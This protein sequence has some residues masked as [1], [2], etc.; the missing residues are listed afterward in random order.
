MQ[1]DDLIQQVHGQLS[2][3]AAL[4]DERTREIAA[5]LATTLDPA[6]RLAIISALADAADEITVA[7][8]DT[9]GSPAISLRLDGDQ[10]RVEVSQSAPKQAARAADE[11]ELSARISFRLSEALKAGV[12]AAAA[13]DGLSVNSWLVRVTGSA[14]GA[15]AD[16]GHHHNS[17]RVSGWING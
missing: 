6:V 7:L 10:L 17:Q 16:R 4:G 5:T 11:G 2:A 12:E 9:P 15:T 1:L 14:I 3:S 8:L 13:H